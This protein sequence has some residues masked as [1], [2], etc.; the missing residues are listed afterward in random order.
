M[1]TLQKTS[2]L[3]LVKESKRWWDDLMTALLHG[4]RL[5]RA[6]TER[7]NKS[8]FG[9]LRI[10]R[11]SEEA[12]ASSFLNPV[13]KKELGCEGW[14]DDRYITKWCDGDKQTI[15]RRIFFTFFPYAA[16]PDYQY[17][18]A[19]VKAAVNETSARAGR[20]RHKNTTVYGMMKLAPQTTPENVQG[21][22]T[23][24]YSE[25]TS[26]IS[27]LGHTMRNV[28]ENLAS[29]AAASSHGSPQDTKDTQ[30]MDLHKRVQEQDAH[31][32]VQ[33]TVLDTQLKALEREQALVQECQNRERLEMKAQLIREQRLN[34]D[35]RATAQYIAAETMRQN[36]LLQMMQLPNFAAVSSKLSPASRITFDDGA[37]DPILRRHVDHLRPVPPGRLNCW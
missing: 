28:Q 36:F 8:I 37:M 10:D 32:L 21:E 6:Q 26:V 18:K 9:W 7:T 12:P 1:I 5:V 31:A 24:Q 25:L 14:S 11:I 27:T 23:R 33:K 29:I 15:V 30:T 35:A 34:D 17:S 4:N 16:I 22:P 2:T 3:R 19:S 20:L 13:S